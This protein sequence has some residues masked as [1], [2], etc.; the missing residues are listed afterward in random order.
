MSQGRQLKMVTVVV[1]LALAS[2]TGQAR[3]A[4]CGSTSA[5]SRRGR[6]NLPTRRGHGASAPLRSLPSCRR[7]IPPWP[8]RPTVGRGAS[9][10]RSSNSLRSGAVRPSSRAGVYQAVAGGTVCIYRATLR[11]AP[12]AAARHLGNGDG[13]REPTRQPTRFVGCGDPRL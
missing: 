11:S 6:D 3:A 9:V 5:R 4:Q 7:P 10:C 12:G 2:I 1:L 13:V 8:S